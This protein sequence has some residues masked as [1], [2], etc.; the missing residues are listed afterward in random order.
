M[1]RQRCDVIVPVKDA[2]WWV[3]W[4]LE[5]LFRHTPA[6]ELGGVVVVDDGSTPD[7]YSTLE[8]ICQRF[9]VQLV[10]NP[11][12]PG[13]GGACNHGA[14]LC[15]SPYVLFLNTDC[16]VTPGTVRK[17]VRACEEDPSVGLAC[18]LSNNS[19]LLSFPMFPGRSYLE[20]NALLEQAAERVVWED[21]VVEACTIVGNCLLVRRSTF[22]LLKGFDPIWGVGYGEETDLQMRALA[23]GLRGVCVVSSYVFHFGSASFRLRTDLGELA[24][25]NHALFLSRWGDKYKQLAARCEGNSPVEVAQRLL[26]ELEPLGD[27]PPLEPSVLF[28][29]PAVR[30]G[31]GGIH[32]VVDIC[33]HLIRHGVKA[34]IGILGATAATTG[35]HQYQ[36]PIL[37]GLLAFADEA[38]LHADDNIQPKCVASTIFSTA[39]PLRTYALARKIPLVEFIQGYEAYFEQG[40]RRQDVIDSYA[41]ADR[42]LTT[43]AWLKEQLTRFAAGGEVK[44]LPLGVNRYQFH[45]PTKP[46][47]Q[48]KVRVA[49]VLRDAADKG[50]WVLLEVLDRL[51]AHADRFSLTLLAGSAYEVPPGWMAQGDT[52]LIRLPADRTALSRALRASDVL[53]DASFHEGYGLFPLEAMA[54]GATVVA[55]DSGGVRQFLSDGESG[56]L[57]PALNQP[58]AYVDALLA[59]E[60]DRARLAALQAGALR[61]AGEHEEVRCLDGYLEYFRRPEAIGRDE[62]ELLLR[63]KGSRLKPLLGQMGLQRASFGELVLRSTGED[64]GLLL[65]YAEVPADQ[66]GILRLV[67][68]SPVD[69][70]LQLFLPQEPEKPG[71]KTRLLQTLGLRHSHVYAEES[72]VKRPIKR[73]LNTLVL[74]VPA[75]TTGRLR[76]DPGAQPGEFHLRRCEL[77]LVPGASGPL[78]LQGQDGAEPLFDLSAQRGFGGVHPIAHLALLRTLVLPPVSWGPGPHVIDLELASDVDAE[79]ALLVRTR[80]LGDSRALHALRRRIRPGKNRLSFVL[81]WPDIEGGLALSPGAPPGKFALTWMEIWSRSPVREGRAAVTG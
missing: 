38:A 10:R 71:K 20:M 64:P 11:G 50:Q 81:P 29:L 9:P 7:S 8:A 1:S 31:V 4:C 79:M 25:R 76:L 63:V 24:R 62:G 51:H 36:E 26:E 58:Q 65:P 34:S 73:G 55:S 70:E 69:T 49:V 12:R 75:G 15:S 16:F 5:E 37:C 21:R 60:A 27:I 67:L 61:V 18:P 2:V 59:L 57:I 72:S 43:S 68:T 45:P 66:R 40:T 52:E 19:P 54:S 22:D 78:D 80:S 44:Q 28:L 33:N 30:Q 56:V 53:V 41:V 13:F 77:R 48:G 14:S 23:H 39:L 47:R 74:E 42:L 6:E 46:R 3:A 32:A 17:L 35:V